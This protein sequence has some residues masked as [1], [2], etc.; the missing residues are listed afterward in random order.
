MT[1]AT[2]AA[3]TAAAT[4]GLE[5]HWT[6]FLIPVRGTQNWTHGSVF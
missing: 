5:K 3:A 4:A 1:L 6:L 2:A